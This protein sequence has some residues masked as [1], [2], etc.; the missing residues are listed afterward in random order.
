VRTLHFFIFTFLILLSSESFTQDKSRWSLELTLATSRGDVEFEIHG[1]RR[2]EVF[3]RQVAEILRDEARPILDYFEYPPTTAIH[4]VVDN[5]KTLANGSATV[6]PRNQIVLYTHPP[7][8]NSHLLTGEDFTRELVLHE[9]THVVHMDQTRSTLKVMRYLFGSFGKWGG[10]V[11]RWFAEGIATWA[12]THFTRGGRVSH[13]PLRFELSRL[14]LD[15]NFCSTIDCID[16]PGV[17][18]HGQFSYWVGS[19]FLSWLEE[20]KEGTV[21]CLVY[22]NSGSLP[23]L[24]NNAFENCTGLDAVANFAVF[25]NARAEEVR[26]AQNTLRV[27]IPA[28]L[29]S[30]DANAQGAIVFQSNFQ[31]DGD[32]LLIV[33]EVDEVKRPA[34]LPL[35]GGE[36]QTI[37]TDYTINE[38]GPGGLSSGMSYHALDDERIVLDHFK[39]VDFNGDFPFYFEGKLHALRFSDNAWRLYRQGEEKE[40]FVFPALMEVKKA[41]FENGALLFNGTSPHGIWKLLP[42]PWRL[43]NSYR[44]SSPI[45]MIDSCQGEVIFEE[46]KLYFAGAKKRPLIRAQELGLVEV[47]FGGKHSVMTFRDDPERLYVFDGD[48]VQTLNFLAEGKAPP[49]QEVYHRGVGVGVEPISEHS[50]PQFH[51]YVPHYWMIG[52]LSTESVSYWSLSSSVNDPLEVHTLSAT[53]KHYP[54]FESTRADFSYLYD[55]RSTYF[56]LGREESLTDSSARTSPDRAESKFAQVSHSFDLA[57]GDLLVYGRSSQEVRQDVLSSRDFDLQQ[58]SLVYSHARLFGDEFLQLATLRFNGTFQERF[59]GSSGK[60]T[61]ILRPK[62]DVYLNL[63]SSYGKLYK[64]TFRGG[65][66][67][68]GGSNEELHDFYGLRANDA[69]GLEIVTARVQGEFEVARAYRGPGLIP[70]FVKKLNLLAGLDYLKTD[71]IYSAPDKFFLRNKSLSSAHLGA[72]AKTVLFYNAPIDID[73]LWVKTMNSH[74]QDEEQWLTLFRGAFFP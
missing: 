26:L 64:D 50:Y 8:A 29:K 19:D 14:Y 65:A 51:H 28:A 57:A 39:P 7:V 63:K 25:R 24:L 9:L 74:G 72:R 69:F 46:D 49:A 15:P 62:R 42:N 44:A 40:V 70:L 5:G 52:Y 41:R 10:I 35:N 71:Y 48:C 36:A 54:D 59:F 16:A 4:F 66:I 34:R 6:F 23:F 60:F 43:E 30:L 47:R 37:A 27:K 68:G 32:D 12:E 21:R 3:M 45:R 53:A 2:D 55:W 31:V 18:P 33:R 11:P 22:E 17:Y 56:L 1:E 20:K 13:P 58:L 61:S 38:I 67:F 73:L